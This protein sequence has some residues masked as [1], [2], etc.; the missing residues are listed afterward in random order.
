MGHPQRHRR[1]PF[2]ADGPGYRRLL[3]WLQIFGTVVLIGVE[4]TGSYGAGLTRHLHDKL[5]EDW[6]TWYPPP[7]T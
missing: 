3:S 6:S 4:G 7:T 5:N 1:T 2:P